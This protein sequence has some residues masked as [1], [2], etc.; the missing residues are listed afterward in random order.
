MHLGETK[1][2]SI[3]SPPYGAAERSYMEQFPYIT[4]ESETNGAMTHGPAMNVTA[5]MPGDPVHRSVHIS[6]HRV[7]VGLPIFNY[8]LNR[9]RNTAAKRLKTIVFGDESL[10]PYLEDK[11]Q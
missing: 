1:G 7:E 6:V 2:I 9:A 10:E 3:F 11:R 4:A 5:H 8:R